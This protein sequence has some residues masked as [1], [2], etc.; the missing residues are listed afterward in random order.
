[1]SRRCLLSSGTQMPKRQIPTPQ[2]LSILTMRLCKIAE[3]PKNEQGEFRE[4]ISDCVMRL[5]DRHATSS[6]PSKALKEAVS[7]ARDL[8]QIFYRLNRQNRERLEKTRQSLMQFENGKIIHL[9]STILNLGMLFSAAIGI[10]PLV[11]RHLATVQFTVKDQLL[12]ELVFSL[13]S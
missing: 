5:W 1:R 12:R 2:Q 11:P 7:A 4:R 9:E 8:Q 3:V 10:P 13:L 6:N